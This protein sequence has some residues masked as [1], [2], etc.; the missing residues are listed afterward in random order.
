MVKVPERL[1]GRFP[2]GFQDDRVVLRGIV[3]GDGEA[4]F[5]H[6]HRRTNPD[7]VRPPGLHVLHRRCPP[8]LVDTTVGVTITGT[9]HDVTLFSSVPLTNEDWRQLSEGAVVMA[10]AGASVVVL[11]KGAMS[12]NAA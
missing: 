11:S 6:G 2:E 5:G 7:G 10:I 1:P 12:L 4:L 3:E 8:P 9:N